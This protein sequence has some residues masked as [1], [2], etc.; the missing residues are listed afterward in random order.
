MDLG[1]P[2]VDNPLDQQEGGVGACAGDDVVRAGFRR[3]VLQTAGCLRR[4][5]PLLPSP[6]HRLPPL[7][8]SHELQLRRIQLAAEHSHAL[9]LRS[10]VSSHSWRARFS[11]P[12]SVVFSRFT[13]MCTY[14]VYFFIYPIH[15]SRERRSN[16][17]SSLQCPGYAC[18]VA[19]PKLFLYL[20]PSCATV[21][22]NPGGYHSL[23]LV[24]KSRPPHLSLHESAKS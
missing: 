7:D 24:Q 17:C 22:L 3:H 6:R 11:S 16:M 5:R 1:L 18:A 2:Q 13:A 10:E 20:L 4:R 23:G 8:P 19:Y 14:F 15:I 12:C 9:P 21:A